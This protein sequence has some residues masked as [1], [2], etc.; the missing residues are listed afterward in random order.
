MRIAFTHNVRLSTSEQEAEF[1]TPRTIESLAQSLAR[2]GH[3]VELVEVSGPASRTVSRLEAL[4]PDLIFNTAE[5]TRGRYR[6][7]FYP[8]LFEQL[9][10]PYTGSDAYTCALTLD[11]EVTQLLLRSRGIL[12]P[13]GAFVEDLA[14][15]SRSDLRFPLI[16]KPNFEGSSKGIN[17]DAVVDTAA[18]L[19]ER[20]AA[21]LAAYP[22]G[23]LVEEYIA[24]IDVTVGFLERPGASSGGILPAVEYVFDPSV[25][26]RKYPIYDYALKHEQTHLI[27]T[28]TPPAL[29]P[30]RLTQ[31]AKIARAAV[32][33]LGLRDCATVD[34]RVTDEGE[35]YVID[36]NALPAL[37]T[38][39]VIYTA[40]RAGGLASMDDVLESI[41]KSAAARQGL[42][43]RKGASVRRAAPLRVGFTYNVKRIDP[44]T[45]TDDSEAEYDSP[46]TIDA[47]RQALTSFGHEVI[48]LEATPELP[49]IL[50]AAN[51]D[52]V[53]NMAEGIKGRNREAQVP[54]I[55]ELLDIPYTGSDPAALS[56]ALDKGMAKR[57]VRQAGIA[58]PDFVLMTTGKE[59]LPKGMRFPVI[60]KP[61]AEGS[62][63]GVVGSSVA[64]DEAE[65]RRIVSDVV[66]KYRQPAL[67]EEY[68]SGREFTI[69]LLG[70]QRPRALPPM[71][72]VFLTPEKKHPVYS[73]EHK[74]DWCS[75]I[76]YDAPAVVDRELAR[77]LERAA[78]GAFVAL[79]CR[80]VGRVDLRCDA[81]GRVNFIECN[82]LPGLTPDWSDLCLILKS[83][84]MDYRMLIGEI[85]AL[86]I[87]RFREKT[88]AF[89]P[90]D[91]APREAAPRETA[92][93]ARDAEPRDPAPRDTAPPPAM[94]GSGQA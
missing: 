94:E 86:A 88:R 37:E 2:L 56:L 91:T 10:I 78:R 17:A 76:R 28:R 22:Q 59:R 21:T 38:D 45:G 47:I 19:R 87:K 89:R 15:F 39:A 7:A 80:D 14:S 42:T 25:L 41:L 30:D 5:G 75:D 29:T 27:S 50:A 85:L 44:K 13:S 34:F 92:P 65:M 36:V 70:E 83:A 1:D 32:R 79:G 62:S 73:F 64:E 58:T 77:E 33:V 20:L 72:I 84:G 90:R 43:L 81:Q 16:V 60:V 67:V 18:E 49:S 61:V 8:G 63:K 6:E 40:A 4:D 23:V 51:V 74:L 9:G 31:L 12:A 68:L 93:P 52:L 3:Q 48:D 69:A 53:F 35:L 24:G 71:E 54:A 82:P 66:N 26:E 46:K 11:K 55:L 57:I